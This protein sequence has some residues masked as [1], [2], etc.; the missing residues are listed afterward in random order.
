MDLKSYIKMEFDGITHNVERTLKD[1]TADDITW[2]PAAGCNSIGIILYHTA[3]SE[4][5]MVHGVLR[6]QPLIYKKWTEKIGKAVEDEGDHYS[7]EQVNAFVTPEVKEILAYWADVRQATLA[8]IDSLT[9]AEWQKK[10]K[11]PWGRIRC[12][13]CIVIRGFSHELSCR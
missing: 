9:E 11:L 13:R 8:Y 10:T 6:K 5:H 7:V 2:R 3:R 12:G 4:D 1:L